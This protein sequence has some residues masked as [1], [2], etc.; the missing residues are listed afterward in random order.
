[1][2][3]YAPTTPNAQKEN[4]QGHV[5]QGGVPCSPDPRLLGCVVGLL[6]LLI[7]VILL[8]FKHWVWG[9][10]VIAVWGLFLLPRLNA[11]AERENARA[12]RKS[13]SKDDPNDPK[14]QSALRTLGLSRTEKEEL[15]RAVRQLEFLNE[16]AARIGDF[17]AFC[18]GMMTLEWL[19]AMQIG[20][21]P[22]PEGPM[23]PDKAAWASHISRLIRSPGYADAKRDHPNGVPAEKGIPPFVKSG[24][25]LW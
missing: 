15:G 25:N 19:R 17:D 2:P 1:M 20:R 9:A 22:H 23:P 8:L 11:M 6:V 4:G 24:L 5:R 16:E 3:V 21:E 10:T 12:W 13:L 7:G 18:G 14:T